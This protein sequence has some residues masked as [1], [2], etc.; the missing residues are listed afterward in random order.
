MN[1]LLQQVQLL[2]KF[3][4]LVWIFQ[5]KCIFCSVQVEVTSSLL[6]LHSLFLSTLSTLLVCNEVKGSRR[7]PCFLLSLFF[8]LFS[9]S[10]RSLTHSYFRIHLFLLFDNIHTAHNRKN[11]VSRN[12]DLYNSLSSPNDKGRWNGGVKIEGKEARELRPNYGQVTWKADIVCETLPLIE[13]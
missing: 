11:G 10:L 4:H 5:L 6:W 12:M 7:T 13:S 8:C 1:L 3:G 9:V 2:R